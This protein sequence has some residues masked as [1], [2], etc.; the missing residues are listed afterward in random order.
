MIVYPTFYIDVSIMTYLDICLGVGIATVVQYIYVCMY[1]LLLARMHGD[2]LF[3][4]EE[5]V[6]H[7][8]IQ[9]FRFFR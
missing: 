8:N 2:M 9:A 1:C 3:Y 7:R 4:R 5:C 6:T